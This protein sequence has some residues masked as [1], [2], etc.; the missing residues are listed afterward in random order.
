M[1]IKER[2]AIDDPKN[3]R[4][5][6]YTYHVGYVTSDWRGQ[7]FRSAIIII[8]LEILTQEDVN[9]LKEKLLKVHKKK[10]DQ[11]IIMGYNRLQD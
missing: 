4:G 3:Y 8:N 11:L 6:K 7:T 1:L 2:F 9:Y 5:K 10:P